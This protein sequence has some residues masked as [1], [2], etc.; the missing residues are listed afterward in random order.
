MSRPTAMVPRVYNGHTLLDVYNKTN[1]M[2]ESSPRIMAVAGRSTVIYG[3]GSDPNS[4]EEFAQP[5]RLPP[6]LIHHGHVPRAQAN[7]PNDLP[8]SERW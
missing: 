2:S 5:P 7:H 3:S 6:T 4:D 1:K 8:T